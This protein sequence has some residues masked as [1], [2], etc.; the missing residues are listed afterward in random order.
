MNDLAEIW[1]VAIGSGIG[2]GVLGLLAG[3][4]LRHRSL[5]WQLAVVGVVTTLTVLVGVQAISRRML[6]SDHDRSVV[7]IVTSAA[8]VVSLAV[9]LVLA[10][11]LVR[12]SQSLREEVRRVGA[13]GSTVA[14][15]RGPTEFQ[16]LASDLA[17]AN[18]RLA[19]A[20]EREQRLEDSRREL[21][22]WVSHDLRTPLAGIRAMAEALEDGVAVDPSRY[23][24]QIRGEV[25]RMVVMVDDLFELSR[26]HAGQLVVQPQ[27]VVLGDLVSEALAAADPVARA[28]GVRLDGEV[29]HGLQV[30]A[31]PAGLSRVLANLIV[32]AIRHTPADG[33]VHVLARPVDGGVELAVT[34][35]CG[36]IAD[37][38]RDRVFDVGFRGTSSR[39]PEDPALQDVHTAR[40]G[41]GLAI[42]KGIVE[43]HHG[44]VAVENVVGATA[45]AA[46]C[47][48]RVVLPA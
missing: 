10:T 12:W 21:V 9:S 8:A 32:N 43:A 5:R 48:F 37:D 27:P 7:L 13:G 17:D 33:S 38:A 44:R 47:R 25:D 3:W 34:D 36:G 22:S 18:G 1:A 4:L 15:R 11:A 16:D 45:E 14:E 35:G 41:L 31:D 26:I 39:T 46:G 40:A 2:V 23:H 29:P 30:A 42:V 19:E 6:I 20:R 28:R 24:R